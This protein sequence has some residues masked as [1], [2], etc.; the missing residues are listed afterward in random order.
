MKAARRG[1]KSSHSALPRVS[2]QESPPRGVPGRKKEDEQ[3]LDI[4]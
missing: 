2:P 3:M 1:A 4:Q